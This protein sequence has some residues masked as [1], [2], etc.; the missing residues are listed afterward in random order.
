[1]RRKTC[2]NDKQHE[3]PTIP[4]TA[5]KLN[6]TIC[7][8]NNKND[9]TSQMVTAALDT[10]NLATAHEHLE[11][12][13]AKFPS[14]QRVRR[15]QGMQ[16]EAEGSFSAA[17]EIYEEML[18]ANPANSLARKRQVCWLSCLVLSCLNYCICIFFL[19]NCLD[20]LSLS[21]VL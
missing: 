2:R 4:A 10:G 14:S 11:V 12:L 21:L 16:C 5:L 17:A 19:R 9:E 1:M 3:H 6:N 8:Y 18:V 20:S 15:L 13:R 7:T